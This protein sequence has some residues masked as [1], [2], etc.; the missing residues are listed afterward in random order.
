MLTAFF[1]GSGFECLDT[2]IIPGHLG[3]VVI[4]IARL[5][6]CAMTNQE[7]GSDISSKRP[8]VATVAI[9]AELGLCL[10]E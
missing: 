2:E 4:S 9:A 5:T 1:A 10:S 7:D 8:F 6:N 3:A